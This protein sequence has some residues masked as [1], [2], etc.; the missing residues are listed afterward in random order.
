VAET[1]RGHYLSVPP[2]GAALDEWLRQYS[3]FL[4]TAVRRYKDFVRR[5]EIW[6][7]PNHAAFWRPRPDPGAYRQ[8]Y[9]RLRATILRVDPTAE[10]AVGGLASLTAASD[11]DIPGLALLRR[12]TR[13]RAPIDHVA[14]HPYAT[15]DHS[16]QVHV[17]G[18]NNFDDIERVREQLTAEGERA[19]IWVTEWG[20]SSVTLGERLQARYVN[21]SLAMLEHRY[22]F[23]RVATYFADHDRPPDFF[24][25]LLGE[26]LEP[27][28]A[29]RQF[30]RHAELAASRCRA[31]RAR[32][33]RGSP[34]SRP[35]ASDR[36]SPASRRSAPG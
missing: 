36:R 5:W 28:P 23:V 35:P 20:W 8:V 26:D 16:P 12:L 14:I 30:Q 6:N 17:P 1:T 9:E 31:S 21:R 18:E 2:R 33:P 29:A 22:R 15:G 7:E 10:V 25:G 27:K 32:P 3:E 4:A 34:A 24:H 19:S 11:P 13:T